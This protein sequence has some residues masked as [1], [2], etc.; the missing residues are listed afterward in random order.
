MASECSLVCY[1]LDKDNH[2]VIYL[3]FNCKKN[4]QICESDI[5]NKV[6][7]KVVIH[8][9]FTFKHTQYRAKL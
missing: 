7:L 6:K 9:V 1:S 5:E 8:D 4:L 3:F 2:F